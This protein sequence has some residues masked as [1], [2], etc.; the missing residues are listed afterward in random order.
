MGCR[1]HG[2]PFR[3][4]FLILSQLSY[5]AYLSELVTHAHDPKFTKY[6]IK[7]SPPPFPEASHVTVF[8]EAPLLFPLFRWRN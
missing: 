6:T 8:E 2:G 3:A 1:L 5:H 4:P 7:K